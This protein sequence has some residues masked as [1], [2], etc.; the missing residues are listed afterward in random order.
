MCG[1]AGLLDF[2]GVLP[3][4]QRMESVSRMS[5]SMVRR[6]PDDDGV[7]KDA[8]TSVCLAFRR[9]AVLDVTQ[10]GHQPMLTADGR[11]VLVFNGEIYNHDFLRRELTSLGHAFRSRTDTEVLLA[12]LV[13]WGVDVLPR[14]NGMFAFAWYDRVNRRLTLARDHAGIKPLYVLLHPDRSAMAFA[15]RYDALAL[16]P[17]SM[18][19][20]REDVMHLYLRLHHIPAPFAMHA[21]ALQLQPG[22][23]LT[24][25]GDGRMQERRWWSIED[26]GEVHVSRP[27]VMAAVDA[28]LHAAV[29]R[30][31]AADVPVG[32]Y[33]SGGV[34]SALV[35]AYS[36][37]HFPSQLD[38][39]TISTKGWWQDEGPD[40]R[41][42]AQ[43]L[44]VAHHMLESTDVNLTTLVE[45][46]FEAQYEPFGDFSMLPTL[47]ISAH[48]RRHVTVALSGD[49]GDE[50]FFGYERPMSL[51]RDAGLFR[52][53]RLLRA[54]PYLAGK[55][56]LAR[57]RSGAVLSRTPAD[58][59]Y[60]VNC[61]I[62]A[63]DACRLVPGATAPP[64][65]FRLYDDGG[66]RSWDGLA[67]YSRRVE[68]EGQLQR[69]LK[70]V[71]MA[72]M[73]HSLEVRVPLLD[74]EVITAALQLDPADAMQD[75]RRKSVLVD[76]L[77]R[78]VDPAIIPPQKR[79]FA[80]PLGEWLRG[81]L[82]PLVEDVIAR[83]SS[84]YP[85]FIEPEAVR[86]MMRAHL[87]G[88]QDHKWG[89]W[90]VLSLL[91]W[92]RR[93]PQRAA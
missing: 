15:S 17:W 33:L 28:S 92:C 23:C 66:V 78:M 11:H 46:A 10:A 27:E 2:S 8:E 52:L 62:S 1:I 89:I 16:C 84:Q 57:R 14:L 70:K 48:A 58:Y 6:G 83:P 87:L 50:L 55:Y 47:L 79:G 43:A 75:G 73:H 13:Q 4:K 71:D 68:F 20:V 63:E 74:R 61:R 32:V 36:T 22:T 7:W 81:S 80:V 40:A 88:T 67:R 39:F 53:P 85:S 44:G 34:D 31:L 64:S 65:D 26:A 35:T 60:N 19:A 21:N 38:A 5:A 51:L 56:G 9:L 76:L 90:T 3:P 82:R 69:G 18:G 93:V 42:Y 12:A 72:S 30:Q 86:S 41:R 45:E 77:G 29:E 37:R 59:Y 24:F 49:G 54:V 25:E 91:E